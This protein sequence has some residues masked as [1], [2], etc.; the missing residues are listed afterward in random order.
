MTAAR[1]KIG[2]VLSGGGARGIA[3]IGV[4]KALEELG[5]EAD[6]VAGTSAGSIVG[7]LYAA[8]MT[9]AEMT[10][11]AESV[12]LIR[13]FTPGFSTKGLISLSYLKTHLAKF[14]EA[15]R[16]E[17]LKKPLYIAVSNL[18]TG[19][20]EV[21]QSGA[22]FDRILASSA[23]PLVF[24]PITDNNNTLVD[25]GLLMNLPAAPI[26]E[27]VDYLIGIDVIPRLEVEQEKLKGLLSMANIAIRCFYLS[28]INNSRPQ[29]KL[30]DLVIEPHG[31]D[32]YTLFQ[33]NK[34]KE[35]I[36]AGY[37]GAMEQKERLLEIKDLA[38]KKGH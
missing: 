18:N 33:F 14:L 2:L 11:F 16:F 13:I 36:E 25:G 4:I 15:T 37:A 35:L 7:A 26:R 23:I 32:N 29:R 19:Q 10:E 9:A 30:C 12:N 28:V 27:Q 21:H 34:S 31:I 3:H 20:L 38:E 1:K 17:E 22:L 24:Q 5:I 8:G 6:M